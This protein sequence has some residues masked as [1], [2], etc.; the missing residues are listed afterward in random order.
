MQPELAP[1]T[2]IVT[3][4]SR[5]VRFVAGVD[6]AAFME[7]DEK[8]SAVFGQI[9]II[10]EAA[11]RLPQNFLDAHAEVPWRKMIG[12]RNRVVHGYDEVDWDIVWQVAG[13]EVPELIHRLR[14]LLPPEEGVR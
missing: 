6:F 11:N 13:D 9:I 14:P 12:M 8:Q 2:D 7:N 10:G 3:A 4:A 1:L 5:I